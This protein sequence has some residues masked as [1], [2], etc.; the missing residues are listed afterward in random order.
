MRLSSKNC[1]PLHWVCVHPA[2][3]L[4]SFFLLLFLF[5][6]ISLYPCLSPPVL[7]CFVGWLLFFWGPS[8]SC[9]HPPS[10]RRYSIICAL[11][12]DSV[13]CAGFQID[14][15]DSL[16]RTCLH[17]AAAGGW[18]SFSREK[19]HGGDIL[20]VWVSNLRVYLYIYSFLV[21]HV[22][23]NCFRLHAYWNRCKMSDHHVP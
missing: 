4:F 19:G 20:P 5:F 15:P 2:L 8:S 10:G 12:N 9:L 22:A 14:T 3:T 13:L 16:G 11:S 7:P 21:T 6:F 18:V 1:L 23:I 17:A